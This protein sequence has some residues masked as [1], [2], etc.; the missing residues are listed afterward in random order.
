[1]STDFKQL[2]GRETH[3]EAQER[4]EKK[5]AEKRAAKEQKTQQITGNGFRILGRSDSA[6]PEMFDTNIAFVTSFDGVTTYFKEQDFY[7]Y[8]KQIGGTLAH[9]VIAVNLDQNKVVSELSAE[10]TIALLKAQHREALIPEVATS[11]PTQKPASTTVV[12]PAPAQPATNKAASRQALEIVCKVLG[13]PTT[14]SGRVMSEDEKALRELCGLS[15]ESTAEVPLEELIF[16]VT[17]RSGEIKRA[18]E[19]INQMASDQP[20]TPA[21]PGNTEATATVP[22]TAS[23][24]QPEPTPEPQPQPQPAPTPEPASEPEPQSQPSGSK[25]SPSEQVT[26]QALNQLLMNSMKLQ[27]TLEALVQ[28]QSG[29]NRERKKGNKGGNKGGKGGQQQNGQQQPNTNAEDGGGAD[30]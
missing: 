10:T 13:V 22:P 19:V 3:A 27:Q 14:A 25:K 26:Q 7:D 30:D 15:E 23:Q 6:A 28:L 9:R 18:I 17:D 2:F 16:R 4:K 11:Q 5:A 24:Q 8:Q 29:N 12:E 1:M 20:A 21:L